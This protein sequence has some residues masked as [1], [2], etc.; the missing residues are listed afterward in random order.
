MDIVID[1]K[2]AIEPKIAR[3]ATTLRNLTAQLE[4]YQEVY[5]QIATLLLSISEKSDIET[6]RQ[7]AKKY[8]QK[9]KIPTIIVEGRMRKTKDSPKKVTIVAEDYE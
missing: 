6:I 9:L 8:A 1:G 5:P 2:Y 7:Y 3:D 4:E